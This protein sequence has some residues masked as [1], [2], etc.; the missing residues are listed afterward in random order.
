MTGKA[1]QS[2]KR[3]RTDMKIEYNGLPV[4]FKCDR[5]RRCKYPKCGEWCNHTTDIDHAVFDGDKT[6][7]SCGQAYFEDI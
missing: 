5:K 1:D 4:V 3:R 7:V 2:M 6:F